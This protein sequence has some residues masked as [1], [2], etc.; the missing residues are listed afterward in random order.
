MKGDTLT[1]GV[2]VGGWVLLL[3]RLGNA[4]GQ[5]KIVVE[6]EEPFLSQCHDGAASGAEVI[7]HEQRIGQDRDAPGDFLDV[8]ACFGLGFFGLGFFGL[9]SSAG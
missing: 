8:A 2:D 9:G 6:G 5:R 4:V 1:P 3:P 7:G